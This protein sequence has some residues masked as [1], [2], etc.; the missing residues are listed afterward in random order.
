M[1]I[2]PGRGLSFELDG[3]LIQAP[4]DVI[5][6]TIAEALSTGAYEA[7][8]ARIVARALKPRD[9]V[10]EI[11]SGLGY[12]STLIA[13]DDRVIALTAVEADPRLAKR[14]AATLRLNNCA[15]A[16]VL[17]A[18]LAP[19]ASMGDSAMFYQRPD[20]WMSSMIETDV[21]Y[22]RA[23][24][25]PVLALNEMLRTRAI[26]CIV[27]DIEGGELELL[28]GADLSG[29]D[30]VVVELHDHITG[31]SGV[32]NLFD[33]MRRKG[34]SYDPRCSEGTVVL[35]RQLGYCEDRR[36]YGAV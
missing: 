18:V 16:E 17:N 14:A 10:L 20:F 8:E 32:S 15:S 35:F 5:T 29:V 34:F 12:V 1:S 7:E 36:P 11:G 23:V 9:R 33:I 28:K 27:C 13:R 6:P 3:V 22:D 2:N 31:L 26:T 4:S 24:N 30:R 21:P 19:E 25:V